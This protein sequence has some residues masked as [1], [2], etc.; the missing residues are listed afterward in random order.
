ML[1]EKL[2]T[3]S[4]P[5][6]QGAPDRDPPG[7]SGAAGWDTRRPT[8]PGRLMRSILHRLGDPAI[9]VVLWNDE[10]ICTSTQTPIASVRLADRATLLKLM[11]N[12]DLAFGEGYSA[13]RITVRGDLAEL[14][15]EIYR[16][17]FR[18]D[19]LHPRRRL[20]SP[21]RKRAGHSLA[22]SRDNIHHHYDIGN[23]FYS[24]WLG[25][26]MAYTCA[27]FPSAEATLDQAQTAKMHHVSRKLRLR[28]GDRVIEAGCGWGS[29]ALHMARHYRVNVTAFNISHE[30]IVYARERAAEEG[31]A[32]QVQF[33]EEDYRNVGK[34]PGDYDAFV[35][36]GMLEHVSRAH[37]TDFGRMIS[38]CLNRA[39][40]GLIHSIGRIQ[41]AP[42]SPWIAKHIFPGAHAPSLKEMT[43]IFEPADLS[44]IDVENLRPHYARTLQC[45]RERFEHSTGIIRRMFD[46]KFVRMWRWYLAGSEAAFSTGDLQL[47]Q[48]TFAPRSNLGLPWTRADLYRPADGHGSL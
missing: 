14:A 31:L 7:L 44:V 12:P 20:R 4:K 39:G 34:L 15:E 8:L 27:Y 47:F 41:P 45:W 35:S 2:P 21:L 40:R 38:R 33:I 22:D 13:G 42:L 26:T 30:Q 9:E 10:A 29:L 24:L 18:L 17:G 43:E 1:H 5:I 6:A 46:E 3:T 19:A 23:D 28:P 16:G 37:Y 25:Q 48:V 36:V 32:G 11:A